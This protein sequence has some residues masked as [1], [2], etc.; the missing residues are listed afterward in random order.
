[1]KKDNSL[2]QARIIYYQLF[3]RLFIYQDNIT[4]YLEIRKI[5]NILKDNPLDEISGQAITSLLEKLDPVSNTRLIEE[6]NEIFYN[7]ETKNIR[8][9]A[10]F[11]DEGFESGK[12]RVE[13]QR[14]LAKTK[15]RRNE[16]SFTEYEDSFPFLM[17]ILAELN[18]L[19][20]NGESEYENTQHCLFDQIL[21]GFV[22]EFSK[23][24]Y[25]HEKS[26]IFKDV[27][28][29]LKSFISFERLYLDVNKPKPKAV[30]KKVNKD[31]NLSEEERERR[32]RNRRLR[33]EEGG[34]DNCEVSPVFD[35]EDDVD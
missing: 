13:A 7:P 6:F 22:D 11:Y 4:I 34:S 15:I 8:T 27:I 24:V 29:I 14:F 12:K 5:L 17:T 26:D 31:D 21:N 3:A 18:E 9:T 25:E 33:K 35:V 1:M 28:I 23:F 10:S 2:L 20:A 19:I 16:Q 32:E 30:V